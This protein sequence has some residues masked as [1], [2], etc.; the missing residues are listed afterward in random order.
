MKKKNLWMIG[1]AAAF[2]LI[3]FAPAGANHCANF[4]TGGNSDFLTNCAATGQRGQAPTQAGETVLGLGFNPTALMNNETNNRAFSTL[5]A[6]AVTNNPFGRVVDFDGC[7]GTPGSSPCDNNAAANVLTPDRGDQSFNSCVQGMIHPFQ[8]KVGNN[9]CGAAVAPGMANTANPFIRDH[10]LIVG[11]L[12]RVVPDP[13]TQTPS[14]TSTCTGA[15]GTYQVGDDNPCV[16]PNS[17]AD[18]TEHALFSFFVW[19]NS[20]STVNSELGGL[21]KTSGCPPATTAGQTRVCMEQSIQQGSRA[22]VGPEAN[23]G[24]LELPIT[25]NGSILVTAVRF[26]SDGAPLQVDSSPSGLEIDFREFTQQGTFE[27]DHR[28]AFFHDIP[29]ATGCTGSEPPNTVQCN[30]PNS[31][32]A[33][34]KFQTQTQT[35]TPTGLQNITTTGATPPVLNGVSQP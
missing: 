17:V 9:E 30:M 24:N 10:E 7:N 26:Q 5:T 28:G 11:T 33:T 12:V 31:T 8:G 6:G 16:N 20:A 2:V 29:N 34:G 13:F 35:I 23:N 15:G 22:A 4:G 32:Y 1:W 25:G 18:V 3:G 27:L 14:L 19:N 21:F